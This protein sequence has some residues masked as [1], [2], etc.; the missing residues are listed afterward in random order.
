MTEAAPVQWHRDADTSPA[1]RLCW[2]LGVGTLLGALTL[3]V[4]GR[5]FAFAA[6]VGGQLV[7]VAGLVALAV[8]IIALAVAGDPAGRLA[9]ASRRVPGF[10]YTPAAEADRRL[11]RG[12]DAAVGAVVMGGTIVAFDTAIEGNVGELLAAATIPLALV[13]VLLA[14]FLRSTGALDREEG[15][16]YLYDPEDAI[17]IDDLDGVSIHS[18]GNSAIARLHYRTPD[19]EYVPGPRGL[20]LPR[21]VALELQSLVE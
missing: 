12:I 4:F 5:L 6:Q 20:V 21:D 1:I 16:L 13:F 11:K 15:V 18:L 10:E 3:V 9:A 7:L 19:G 17:D 14:V 2:A 8:T